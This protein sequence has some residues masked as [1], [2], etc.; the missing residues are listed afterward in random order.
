MWLSYSAFLSFRPDNGSYIFFRNVWL[1]SNYASL[2]PRRARFASNRWF[3]ASVSYWERC[4]TDGATC[5]IRLNWFLQC[6]NDLRFL[7]SISTCSSHGWISTSLAVRRAV[8]FIVPPE[9]IDL[10]SF[11]D[12]PGTQNFNVNFVLISQTF[13]YL[14][15]K[16]VGWKKRTN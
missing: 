8:F 10:T 13:G 12:S 2:E 14:R 3:G 4:W 9:V 15:S 16:A 7:R 11:R 1:S 5:E 6:N